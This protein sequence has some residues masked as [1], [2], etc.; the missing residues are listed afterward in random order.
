MKLLKSINHPHIVKYIDSFQKESKFYIIMEYCEKG[1]L[2]DYLQRTSLNFDIPEWKVW[3]IFI[4]MCLALE[5]IH[6]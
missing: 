3:K 4:Q 1:D 2:N 6:G 5:C